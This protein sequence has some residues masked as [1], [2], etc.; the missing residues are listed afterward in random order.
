MRQ[1]AIGFIVTA[2][3]LVVGMVAGQGIAAAQA[4]HEGQRDGRVGVAPAPPRPLPP[5]PNPQF[6]VGVQRPIGPGRP[7][8]HR[9]FTP[10][11]IGVPVYVPWPVSAGYGDSFQSVTPYDPGMYYQGTYYPS[12]YYPGTYYAP[13]AESIAPPPPPPPPS[14]VEHETGRYE[15]RGDG[16]AA[17]YQWVW[18]P[19]PP[20]PPPSHPPA[21]SPVPPVPSAPPGPSVA[22]DEVYRFTDD[23]GVIHWTDRWDSIPDRY[24]KQAKRLPL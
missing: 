2:V 18:I 11:V 10:A 7:F 19:N 12:M 20:P 22:S 14:V 15:L 8:G 6:G 5:P 24:R 16:V 17:P 21:A 23:Q 13:P 3:F 1:R 4:I 9:P